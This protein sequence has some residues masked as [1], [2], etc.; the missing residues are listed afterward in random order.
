MR[1]WGLNPAVVDREGAIAPAAGNWLG[2]ARDRLCHSPL[3]IWVKAMKAT[4]SPVDGHH[5][6]DEDACRLP[7][8]NAGL[9]VQVSMKHNNRSN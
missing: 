1:S 8:A 6:R 3:M 4:R 5:Y 9:L 7:F 2:A